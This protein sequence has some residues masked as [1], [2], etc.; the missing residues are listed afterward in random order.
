MRV[1]LCKL[2]EESCRKPSR[3]KNAGYRKLQ[4]SLSER[5]APVVL[6]PGPVMFDGA[7]DQSELAGDGG[8]R[9]VVVG[10]AA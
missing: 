1:G 9:V 4:A 2:R 7:S 8:S 3:P 10:I 6:E 5:I